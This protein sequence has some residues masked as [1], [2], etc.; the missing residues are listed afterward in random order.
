MFDHIIAFSLRQRLLVL[1][2]AVLLLGWGLNVAVHLPVDVFPDLN[3]P[4]V[5]IM[6]E[7]AGL[8]PEETESLVTRPIETAMNGAPGV[9]RVRSSSAVGLSIVYVEFQ[10]G[11]DIYRNRQ[12]VSERLSAVAEQLPAGIAPSMGPISSIMGEILLVGMQAKDGAAT[13]MEVRTIADWVV[14]QRLMSIP[15][16]A[17]VIPIGGAVKQY[18]VLASPSRLAALGLTYQQLETAL[19][20]FSRNTTGGFLE[21]RQSE[22]LIRNLGQTT[23]VADLAETVVAWQNG[24][25]ITVGQVAEVRLG[26]A[27]KRGDASVDGRPAVILAVQKQPG[28]DTVELTRK[29]EAALAELA[30]SLPPGISADRIL[31][32]QAD[33]IERAIANVEEALRDGAILVTIVLFAFL[34]N[35]RTTFISLTAIPLSMVVTILVFHFMGLSINTMTL[36]G[37]AVAIGELVDDAVV[38]VE[39]ILRR[40]RENAG[41]AQPRPALDVVFRASSEVRN[42]IVYATV[43]VVLVFL[44]LFALSGIEGRLFAPLGIAYVTSIAASLLVSLTVTPALALT[45]LPA[46][47]VVGHGDSWLVRHLKRGDRRVLHWSFSHPRL[48]LAVPVLLVMAA[49][50]SVPLMGR[51]FLPAFNEGTVT[52]NVLLAPGA[53]L[54]ESNRIGTI[55]EDLIR[56]VP[57]VLSTGRRTGRAELDEHAEGV[58][59]SEIDVD[60]RDNGR[61]RDQILADLRAN[62]ALLPGVVVNIGQPISHRLD[63]LL[64]GV[65]AEIA[66]K[67]YG[68]DLAQ[69]RGLAEQ[70]RALM[71]GIDGLADLQVEKQVL[72]PQVQ[73]RLDRGEAR[74]YGLTLDRLTET[75]EAALNGKVVAS[76]RDG[77]QSFDVVVRL[78]QDWRAQSDDFRQI[79]VDTPAGP[80]PLALLA[81]VVESVGPNV[82]QRDDMRRRIVVLANAHGRDI[83]S[84]VADV[85]ARLAALKLPPGAY[86]AYEGQFQSQQ[87]AARLIGLLALLSLVGIFLVLF[88]HFRSAVLAAIIMANVPMALIGAVVA[89]WLGDRTLSV[90]SMVGFV[91][92][93]GIAARNGIMKISH[94]RHLMRD[95]G[96]AFGPE[97]IVRGSLERLAPVLMTALVAAL[98]LLPL[99]LASGAPGKE[100]LHPVAV[101]IFGGLLSSTLLD[102]IVTPVLFLLFGANGVKGE[103]Q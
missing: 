1:A 90:A 53:S 55:A 23:D 59:Y 103:K 29:V 51:A 75:L 15:G 77:Q 52:V 2:F 72:I 9:A 27:T 20:G 78:A 67:I 14:R 37:L 79:L 83:G 64:S 56:R 89:L 5:T 98:A 30:K 58:H 85:Q 63:H 11:S 21:Q 88:V 43:I 33:F 17:Q 39:N 65:R 18:Q 47:K 94:Y 4:T 49:A 45:L 57:E 62:L 7:A 34:M 25:S 50:A 69:L 22:Y 6:T 3:R 70:A 28:A 81:E 31:F 35:M 68:D 91:T 10:W 61:A 95:E 40:L 102:T 12:L 84:V 26:A 100:I 8:A 82:V 66:V 36:G 41:L 13:A 80:V 71:T 74:K 93:T 60:L 48:V 54:S 16:I 96:M 46:A 38:D 73:I 92:L 44:P 86:I 97:M 32:R 42:S 24:A 76:V 19:A 99:V 101:V 87:Q